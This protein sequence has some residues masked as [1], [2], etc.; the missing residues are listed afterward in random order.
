MKKYFCEFLTFSC[1]SVNL[2]K[3]KCF[4]ASLNM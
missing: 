4:R 3:I 2:K 1:L